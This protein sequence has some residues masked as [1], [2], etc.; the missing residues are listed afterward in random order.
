MRRRSTI[1][2]IITALAL[3]L[4]AIGA[5]HARTTG[6]K[7][8]TLRRAVSSAIHKQYRMNYFTRKQQVRVTKIKLN[9]NKMIFDR[10]GG[11]AIGYSATVRLN[12]QKIPASGFIHQQRFV[13]SSHKRI[14]TKSGT[15]SPLILV[16]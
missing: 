5:T 12:G 1:I 3:T 14:H 10:S 2:G 6:A 11:K 9:P 16:R 8:N 7:F 4:G 13:P 15:P